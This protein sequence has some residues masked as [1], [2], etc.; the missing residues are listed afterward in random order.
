MEFKTCRSCNIEKQINNYWKKK[1]STDGLNS[2]CKLCVNKKPR[3]CLLCYTIFEKDHEG[4][5]SWCL[6]NILGKKTR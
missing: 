2:H 1:Q 5:C 6:E 4:T 3:H